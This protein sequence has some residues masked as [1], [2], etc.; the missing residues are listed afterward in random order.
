[1]ISL[2]GNTPAAY[3]PTWHLP[4]DPDRLTYAQ[5]IEIASD[6]VGSDIFYRTVPEAAFKVLG[7]FNPSVKE[8]NELMPRYR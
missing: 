6:V 3:G 7:L 2:I 1:M 5:M 4:I 8:A